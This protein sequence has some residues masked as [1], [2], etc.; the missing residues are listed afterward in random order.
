MFFITVLTAN[1]QVFMRRK[2]RPNELPPKYLLVQISTGSKRLAYLQKFGNETKAKKLKENLERLNEKLILDFKNN[3]Q[4]CPVY[5][6]YDTNFALVRDQKFEGVLLSRELQPLKE[7][8]IRDTNYF[9]VQYGRINNNE[10]FNENTVV[11]SDWKG[12]QLKHPLPYTWD[13]TLKG[14]YSHKGSKYSFKS[15]D[16]EIDYHPVAEAY[17]MTLKYFYR[18]HTK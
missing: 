6:Y 12:V 8:P 10:E 2:A 13:H 7:I 17:S 4:F 9:L 5:F 15:K 11:A 14:V 18:S 3:F 1:G 16:Y